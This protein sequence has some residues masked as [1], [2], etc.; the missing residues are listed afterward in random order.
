MKVILEIETDK[1]RKQLEELMKSVPGKIKMVNKMK[2]PIES[3]LSFAEKNAYPV[4]K[5]IIPGRDERNER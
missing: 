5:V 3:L 1:D 2:R 4:D